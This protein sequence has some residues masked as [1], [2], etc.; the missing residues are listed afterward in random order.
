MTDVA[1]DGSPVPIYAALP[2]E[3]E[4][5]RVLSLLTPHSRVL[6]LGCG[7][8]RI[9]NRLAGAGHHVVAV[10]DSHEMLARV[11]DAETVLSDVRTLDLADRF[12]VVLALSH[13]INHPDRS[14]RLDL[15]RV[16]RR[17]LAD[18]GAVVIERYAPDWIPSD[19]E[20][21][22]GDIDIRLHDVLRHDDGWFAA[23]VTYSLDGRSWSQTFTG[24]IVDDGELEALARAS[25]LTIREP[26]DD[27]TWIVLE[28]STP[29]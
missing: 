20:G 9:A 23:T 13:L 28:A 26:T 1:P 24:T 19:A 12:D 25:D 6:D 8:G 21:T 18:G 10:D 16:C 17:H 11:V 4:L 7:T 15:L 22:V 3:P 29:T 2:A 14:C 27:P 5:S